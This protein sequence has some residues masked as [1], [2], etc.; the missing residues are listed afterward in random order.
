MFAQT[1]PPQSLEITGAPRDPALS[2][3]RAGFSYSLNHI[4]KRRYCREPDKGGGRLLLGAK[5]EGETR[6]AAHGPSYRSNRPYR[7]LDTSPRNSVLPRKPSHSNQKQVQF[8]ARQTGGTI[9]NWTMP[10]GPI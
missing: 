4:R 10:E 6:G 8:R 2:P 7:L 3:F 9:S 1:E 5:W